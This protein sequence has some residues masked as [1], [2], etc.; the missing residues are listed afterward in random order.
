VRVLRRS[1]VL[2]KTGLGNTKLYELI[3]AG[4]FPRSFPLL[5]ASPNTPRR[6]TEPVA[7]LEDEIDSW[8]SDRVREARGE[9]AIA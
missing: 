2:A 7:W 3:K 5:P 4:Q 1:Q 9:P 6:E 8:I